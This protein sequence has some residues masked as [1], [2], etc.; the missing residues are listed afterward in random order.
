[1]VS[2]LQKW[3]N[4]SRSVSFR[5]P[6]PPPPIPLFGLEL[7]SHGRIK[8]E[9]RFLRSGEKK[10]NR[11]G[12]SDA[13]VTWTNTPSFAFWEE[14]VALSQML[15]FLCIF[16]PKGLFAVRAFRT[17]RPVFSGRSKDE[18]GRAYN[19]TEMVFIGPLL[20]WKWPIYSSWRR[21]RGEQERGR[22]RQ[23]TEIALT[24]FSVPV[25]KKKEKEAVLFVNL[26]LGSCFLGIGEGRERERERERE[27][28]SSSTLDSRP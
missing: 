2:C 6:L 22:R 9:T 28:N 17:L 24:S 8:Y 12:E 3:E 11:V 20:K 25:P 4:K 5:P 21:G 13:G 15:Q 7:M 18:K 19:E 1:M 26:F 10:E 23:I 14:R 27:R 16:F